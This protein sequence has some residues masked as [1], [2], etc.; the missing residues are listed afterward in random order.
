VRESSL[1]AFAIRT[2]LTGR[3][4]QQTVGQRSTKKQ[5]EKQ[6]GVKQKIKKS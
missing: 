1:P 5:Q 6:K 4:Y 3:T 2:G